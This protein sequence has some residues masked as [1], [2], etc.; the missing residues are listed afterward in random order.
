MSGTRTVYRGSRGRFAGASRGKA[1]QVRTNGRAVSGTQVRRG[2]TGGHGHKGFATRAK[3]LAHNRKVQAGVLTAAT[4]GGGY[5]AYNKINPGSTLRKSGIKVPGEVM[6]YGGTHE[7]RPQYSVVSNATHR[8]TT[9]SMGKGIKK[10]QHTLVEK[11]SKTGKGTP[12]GYVDS[13]RALLGGYR[14]SHTYLTRANRGQGLGK[15]ALAA[16]AAHRPN[17]TYRASMNRSTMGQGFAKSMGAAGFR[18]S[19]S[20]K[21]GNDI[22]KLLDKSW[23]SGMRADRAQS[24]KNVQ[25]AVTVMKAHKVQ[26]INNRRLRKR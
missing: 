25:N 23:S 22:T 7:M 21:A 6:R 16:H 20:K 10:S 12:I 14:V 2:T 15:Q 24:A 19:A 17:R 13:N 26:K 3:S 5:L 8:Y 1:E 18:S 11:L 4:V 9:F